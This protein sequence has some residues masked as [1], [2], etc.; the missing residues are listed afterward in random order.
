MYVADITRIL[1]LG[2]AG[3]TACVYLCP[4]AGVKTRREAIAVYS[5]GVMLASLLT[6]LFHGTPF[7]LNAYQ[8]DQHYILAAITKYRT[9]ST[10]TDFNYAHLATYYPPLYFYV[11]GKLSWLLHIQPYHMVKL[12]FIGAA[13]VLPPI[14]YHAWSPL[15][16]KR[17]AA[18]FVVLMCLAFPQEFMYKTYEF[19]TAV[20]ILPWWF[21]IGERRLP[22][23]WQS[24]KRRI[25]TWI[26]GGVVGAVLFQTYYYWFFVIACYLLVSFVLKCWMRLVPVREAV[27]DVWHQ[28]RVLLVVAVLSA[29]YWLPLLYQILTIGYQNYQNRWLSM[30]MMAIHPFES[31]NSADFISC[32]LFIGFVYL[33]LAYGRSAHHQVLMNFTVA[34]FLW[35]FIG[36]V[37]IVFG[38]PNLHVKAWM[39]ND[40]LLFVGAALGLDAL[41]QRRGFERYATRVWAFALCLVVLV[42]GQAYVDDTTG[43]TDATEGQLY[44]TS[45]RDKT[46]PAYVKQLDIVP[47]LKGKVFLSDEYAAID[48]Q[49]IYL[50]IGDN[51][52]YA[53]P[54]ARYADRVHFLTAFSH[55]RDPLAEAWLLRYNEFGAV[56]DIWMNQ[57]YLVIGL[58]NYPNGTRYTHLPIPTVYRHASEFTRIGTTDIYQVEAVPVTTVR[59]FSLYPLAVAAKYASANVRASVVTDFL[60]RVKATQSRASLRSVLPVVTGNARLVSAVERQLNSI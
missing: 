38:T 19:A 46:P 31:W 29:Y 59:Q 8:G 45:F 22:G 44:Q 18:L 5:F 36:F 10:W 25:W 21:Y 49:P 16:G 9:F 39:F 35:Y 11:L 20:L 34:C 47:N 14:L 40:Q 32:V 60:A 56:D 15:L 28:I 26:I 54:V 17:A 41:L 1:L 27:A 50:F 58:D 42:S 37:G 4:L 3:L 33:L 55:V 53:N 6:V 24:R 30:S 2:W 23:L 7:G 52:N 43:R 48:F 12:A 13:L 57:P 51:L